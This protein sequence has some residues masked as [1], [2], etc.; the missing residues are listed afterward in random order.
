MGDYV[1]KNKP[2]WVHHPTLRHLSMVVSLMIDFSEK[3]LHAL[4]SDFFIPAAPT[5]SS[6]DQVTEKAAAET[7]QE[8]SAEEVAAST[9]ASP[10]PPPP[11]SQSSFQFPTPSQMIIQRF[12]SLDNIKKWVR[13][14]S[15]QCRT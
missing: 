10:P 6:N 11:T 12:P 1:T 5:S 13:N 15:D 9:E 3:L 2:S 7:R 4:K 8:Y 14:K